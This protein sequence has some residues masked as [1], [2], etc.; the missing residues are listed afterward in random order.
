M[1]RIL[2]VWLLFACIGVYAQGQKSKATKKK[3]MDAN[4]GFE[5]MYP[6]SVTPVV[7]KNNEDIKAQVAPFTIEIY[8]EKHTPIDS[9]ADDCYQFIKEHK[10]RHKLKLKEFL[11]ADGA[12]GSIYYSYIYEIEKGSNTVL[13][14]FVH[15][16]CNVCVDAA[17][18]PIPFNEAKDL[19]WVKDIIE[20]AEFVKSR[21]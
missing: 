7:L 1:K 11:C 2:G 14:K 18:K 9:I 10:N 3:F 19:H 13:L 12:A 6:D 16:H 4:T 8:R 17:G 21:K 20:S 15:R 5:L